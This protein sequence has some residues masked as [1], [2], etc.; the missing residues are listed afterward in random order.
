[1][2][3]PRF[4]HA[5]NGGSLEECES[6]KDFW[7]DYEDGERLKHAKRITGSVG[8]SGT[9]AI[10]AFVASDPDDLDLQ[11]GA[12]D[13]LAIVFDMATDRSNATTAGVYE[14][15][16]LYVDGLFTFNAQLGQDYS[17]RWTDDST[18]VVTV[19]DPSWRAGP[20]FGPDGVAD[21]TNNCTARL[22][23]ALEVRNVART[24]AAL[25]SSASTPRLSGN[26]GQD[27][28]PT[29]VSAIGDDPD[30]GDA[31][32]SHGDT[33]T[34]TFDRKVDR[35]GSA[36][37]GP[38]AV[39]QTVPRGSV[40]GMFNFSAVL[41]SDYVGSWSDDSVF[42]VTI[43]DGDT[44]TLLDDIG[45]IMVNPLGTVH[46]QGCRPGVRARDGSEGL[47]NGAFEYVGPIVARDSAEAEAA[48]AAG[49]LGDF[50]AQFGVRPAIMGTLVDDPD[51][52][53]S[54]FGDGDVLHVY[55]DQATTTTTTTTTQ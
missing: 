24:S 6:Y 17:G 12:G 31:S 5:W 36:V 21:P 38:F 14:G 18:F 28:A 37:G 33:L 4:P 29:I 42:V 8:P 16:R 50:H 39:G 20:P 49:K 19:I 23:G 11:Y 26:A 51:A 2:L 47:C 3:G 40:D 43:I 9:P 53:D 30:F 1:M 27:V 35:G 55:F 13:E 15:G 54:V 45:D 7:T 46:N 25:N 22:R 41:G 32:V 48:I 44:S 10:A 34:L 52:G